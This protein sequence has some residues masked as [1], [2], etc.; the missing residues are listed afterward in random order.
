MDGEPLDVKDQT[1]AQCQCPLHNARFS[2]A[3]E[4]LKAVVGKGTQVKVRLTIQDELT[5]DAAHRRCLLE[6]MTREADG[7]EAALDTR[8][9]NY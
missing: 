6:T 9:F 5:H 1:A 8:P 3:A 2:L 7:A 4:P